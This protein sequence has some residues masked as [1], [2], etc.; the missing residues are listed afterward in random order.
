MRKASFTFL[1]SALF[2]GAV[3]AAPVAYTIDPAHSYASFEAP[4]LGVSMFRGKFDV[5]KSGKVTLDSAAKSGTVEVTIDASSID[6][7]FEKMNEHIK[8]ADFFDVAT[9]PEVVYKGTIKY[10]GD[11]P[12]S[13]DGQLTLHGVTK[14]VSLTIKA[15]KCIQHPML[16][17]EDCGVDA[18]GSFDRKE[19]GIAKFADGDQGKVNVLIQAEALKD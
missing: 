14:P 17:R 11:A 6:F 4:H 3:S 9:F 10:K 2:T 18:Y 15:F 19:F 5:T 7:G 8:S 12:T 13:V 1:A 16:K